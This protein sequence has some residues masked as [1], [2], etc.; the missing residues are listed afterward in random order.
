MSD[1]NPSGSALATSAA[2]PAVTAGAVRGAIARA[3]QATGVDFSYLLAQARL[4][5]SLDPTAH[6]ATSSAS[7]LYQFTRGTWSTMLA[8]HGA[9]LGL[10]GNAGDA[11]GPASGA[12]QAQ[13]MDLRY[14]PD[15]AAMMAAE[16][17]GDN[18]AA[19]TTALGRAPTSGELYLAHFLGAAGATKFLGALATDPGQSAAAVLPQAAASNRAIF[20]DAGAPRSLGAVMSLLQARLAVAMQ[21]SGDPGNGITGPVAAPTEPLPIAQQFAAAQAEGAETSPSMADTLRDTFALAGSNAGA[22]PA[23]VRTA[24]GRMQALGL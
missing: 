1:T 13:L 10:G 24:Y 12:A 21:D 7:G 15:T 17:A 5:S 11:T 20:F 6:A 22:A 9:A 18:T 16:L 19:L 3:A 4:E 8:R 23:F 14:D 2:P